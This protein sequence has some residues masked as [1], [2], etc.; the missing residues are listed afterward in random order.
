[1]HPD[2]VTGTTTDLAYFLSFEIRIR[3]LEQVS[4]LGNVVC[5]VKSKVPGKVIG[6]DGNG[7][8]SEFNSF[9]FHITHVGNNLIYEVGACRHYYVSKKVFCFPGIKIS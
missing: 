6:P 1:M 3:V 5:V 4:Y 2:T 8:N 7:V 9:A